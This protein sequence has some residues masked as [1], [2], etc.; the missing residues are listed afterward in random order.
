VRRPPPAA[1]ADPFGVD[2]SLLHRSKPLSEFL[3]RRY[4]RVQAEGVEYIPAAGPALIVANHSGGLPID[5]A[6]IAAAVAIEHPQHRLVR[7]LYDRFVADL[8]VVGQIF[9]R[10]GA[11]VASYENARR[12]LKMREVVGIFPEGVEGVAKTI[13]QRY[14]LQRFHSSFVRLSLALRVPIIPTAVV[15]AEETYPVIGK[16]ERLGPLRKIVNVPYIPVTPLFPWLGVLGMIPLPA[17]FHIRFGAPLRFD[18]DARLCRQR[19][20]ATVRKLADQ[21]R[22]HVQ[23]MVHDLLAARESVF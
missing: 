4:W 20:D 3:Y 17:K 5:A 14:E 15:G 19:D 10:L 6:M 9:N 22:R 2:S 18:A 16:I 1:A 8:P 21:V 23:A 11:T 7:F 13:W 12:L